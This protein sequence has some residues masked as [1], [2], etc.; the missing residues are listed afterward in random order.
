MKGTVKWFNAEKGY[1]FIQVEGGED[2]FVH[3]SAI[4]GDGFKTLEE[5]QAVEFEITEGN[6]GPQAANVIKL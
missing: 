6:R 5:G 3:F 1:G 4:Q 2:V